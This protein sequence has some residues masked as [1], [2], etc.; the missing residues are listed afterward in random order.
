VHA[1]RD[2]AFA[3]RRAAEQELGLRVRDEGN[4]HRLVGDI[5]NRRQQRLP[6]GMR[7]PGVD[8]D[9]AGLADDEAGIADAAEVGLV[10]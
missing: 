6:M 10:G 4:S 1:D 5:P 8:G 2:A 7:G 3:K 9:H